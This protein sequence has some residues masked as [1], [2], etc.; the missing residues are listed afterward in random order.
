VAYQD[1]TTVNAP[2]GRWK[3]IDVLYNRGDG[4]DALAIGEWDGVRVLAS[5]WNG[6][7]KNEG[8]GNPQSRG[9]PTW[10]VQ[11]DWSYAALLECTIIP[12][13]KVG[14]AKALLNLA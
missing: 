3:L 10:F 7:D 5:R 11:P 1:P 12:T 4:G 2:R 14:L 13:A 6:S 9:I 8:I